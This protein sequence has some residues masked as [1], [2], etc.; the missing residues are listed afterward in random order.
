[1]PAELALLTDEEM[2]RRVEKLPN[3]NPVTDFS[4]D[5]TWERICKEIRRSEEELGPVDKS[6]LEFVSDPRFDGWSTKKIKEPTTNWVEQN[7][8]FVVDFKAITDKKNRVLAIDLD[9]EPGRTA[10]VLPAKVG[11]TFSELSTQN[12]SW[13]EIID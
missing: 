9:E 13:D 6:Y 3:L 7:H 2:L 11:G 12:A 8:L 4:D 5:A 10:R 1:M